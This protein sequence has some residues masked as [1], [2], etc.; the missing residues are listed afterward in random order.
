MPVQMLSMPPPSPAALR[1]IKDITGASSLRPHRQSAANRLRA[2]PC[3]RGDGE[4]AN[5][6]RVA[7]RHFLDAISLKNWSLMWALVF[8][9]FPTSTS[10]APSR[11]I[12]LKTEKALI[13]QLQCK[14]EPEVAKALN[15]ML[16]NRLIG[17][18]KGY[19]GEYLFSPK[20]PLKFLGFRINHISGFDQH[21]TFRKAPP[22]QSE[23]GS[24]FHSIQ[25]DIV[26][27]ARQLRIRAKRIHIVEAWT[28]EDH[29]G[30][31]IDGE[32]SHLAPKS[33]LAIAKIRC[34]AL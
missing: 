20:V 5:L 19:D 15:A 32:P 4:R 17:Y 13:D 7:I 29:P 16:K 14:R 8:V 1:S 24:P 21:R 25:I 28:T 27:R 3:V 18:S 23:A 31:E 11:A 12:I 33:P 34:V 2:R 6:G 26:T 22:T 30:L 10:A 9:F